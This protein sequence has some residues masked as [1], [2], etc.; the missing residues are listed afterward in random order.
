MI[1]RL[2]VFVRVFFNKS[3]LFIQSGKF[4][5]KFGLVKKIYLPDRMSVSYMIHICAYLSLVIH[6]LK[7]SN[8]EI[9]CELHACR[10]IL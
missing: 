2:F 10:F 9:Q 7:Y 4:L 1:I 8:I 3:A 6:T 5:L